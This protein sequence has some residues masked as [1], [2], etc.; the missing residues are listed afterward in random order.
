MSFRNYLSSSFDYGLS[1][2]LENIIYL[3]YRSLGYKIYVG[4]IGR[5]EID[6][7]IEKE[8]EKKYI[9]VAYSLSS[10]KVI[11]R[12]FGNL[13]KIHN[14]YEKIVISLDDVSLGSK[15]G[16]KHWRA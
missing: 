10:K 2:H 3:H 16:I 1:G 12:E 13:E 9:Q 7:I 15:N 6:F 11:E 4:R 14:A 8:K 5:A